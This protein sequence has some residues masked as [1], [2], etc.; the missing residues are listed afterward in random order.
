MLDQRLIVAY[1]AW[2][3]LISRKRAKLLQLFMIR[4]NQWPQ[5]AARSDQIARIHIEYRRTSDLNVVSQQVFFFQSRFIGRFF[6]STL[7]PYG[8]W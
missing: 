8:R 3:S 7:L 5:A 1:V 2:F 4:V 6:S